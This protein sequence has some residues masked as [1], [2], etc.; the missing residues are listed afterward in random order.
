MKVRPL[1][2]FLLVLALAFTSTPNTGRADEGLIIQD[3]AVI[4]ITQS[5][6][7]ITIPE[8]VTSIAEYAFYGHSE[9]T[10]VTLPSTLQTI[11][12]YAFAGC[13]GLTG[14]TLPHGLVSIGDSAF[15]NCA[16]LQSV[17]VP[18]TVQHIGSEAFAFA[19][20]KEAVL[21]EGVAAINE[22]AFAACPALASLTVPNSLAQ[23]GTGSI[24]ANKQLTVYT[25]DN[26]HAA[27]FCDE[28]AITKVTRQEQ[29][30]AQ[31]K[32]EGRV[33]Y[34]PE[35]AHSKRLHIAS[36]DA[37]VMITSS[38][39]TTYPGS[40]LLDGEE[41]SSW[42]FSTKSLQSL[43]EAYVTLNLNQPCAVSEV[44]IKNGFW[45]ITDGLDQYERNGR[46]KTVELSFLY[47]GSSTFTE[48]IEFTIP[49]DR[50]SGEFYRMSFGWKLNVT[51]IRMTVCDIYAGSRFKNDVAVS[52]MGINGLPMNEV[53]Y[54]ISL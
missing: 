18:G 29:E 47:E 21:E 17:V 42:Q 9:I 38:S 30:Y 20:L 39:G 53:P 31:A 14:I 10:S 35:G 32:A 37:S 11:G 8:G 48:P 34:R 51:A 50:S 13:G 4:A 16:A 27:S 19:G 2:V 54:D 52:E 36:A 41:T 5:A 46:L 6:V 24:P 25:Q 45:K 1:L 22:R 15:Y 43:R 28:N 26:A 7:Q 3:G 40:H 12:A 44:L 23:I 49:D 33:V